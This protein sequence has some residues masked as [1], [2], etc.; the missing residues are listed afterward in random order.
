MFYLTRMQT[1]MV[2]SH[3]YSNNEQ[4]VRMISTMRDSNNQL[5]ISAN[6]KPQLCKMTFNIFDNVSIAQPQNYQQQKFNFLVGPM[7]ISLRQLCFEQLVVF[8]H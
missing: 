4:H 8:Q 7:I 6:R 2:M 5:I 1:K 3:S